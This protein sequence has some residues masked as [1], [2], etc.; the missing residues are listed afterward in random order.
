MAVEPEGFLDHVFVFAHAMPAASDSAGQLQLAELDHERVEL[1]FAVVDH[2]I[3]IG[4]LVTCTPECARRERVAVGGRLGFLNETTNNSSLF[5][6]EVRGS[7]P[8]D[9][10]GPGSPA[11]RS[12]TN[13]CTE[14]WPDPIL[15]L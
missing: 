9:R 5:R 14:R 1:V 4:R 8:S 6:S 15:R 2:R 7:D 3:P 10:A 13:G 12:S 11:P